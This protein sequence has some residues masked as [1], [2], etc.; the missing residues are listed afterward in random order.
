MHAIAIMRPSWA[1]SPL[2][3]VAADSWWVRPIPVAITDSA[4]SASTKTMPPDQA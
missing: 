2:A 3:I 1:W 4:S